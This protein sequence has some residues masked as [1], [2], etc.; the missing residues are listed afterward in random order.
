MIKKTILIIIFF[1]F[2]FLNLSFAQT[3]KKL[4]Q[5]HHD[6]F[7]LYLHLAIEYECKK[8]TKKNKQK[9]NILRFKTVYHDKL[10]SKYCYN[11]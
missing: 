6:K 11:E 5:V 9:C 4:C 8:L 10:R 1:S 2:T 7:M 3:N